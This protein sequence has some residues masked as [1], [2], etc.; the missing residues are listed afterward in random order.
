[1]IRFGDANKT[2]NSKK[3][4]RWLPQESFLIGVI[5]IFFEA[6]KPFSELLSG[7]SHRKSHNNKNK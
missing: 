2:K 6:N 3:F 7:Q 4:K 5:K 1:M